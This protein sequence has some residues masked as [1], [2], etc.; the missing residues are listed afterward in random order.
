MFDE[1]KIKLLPGSTKILG[2]TRSELTSGGVHFRGTANKK[3]NNSIQQLI[4]FSICLFDEV[5]IKLLL[6]STKIL[7]RTLDPKRNFNFK[8]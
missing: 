7:G 6:G 3:F 5:K 4:K 2:L 8:I 1:I